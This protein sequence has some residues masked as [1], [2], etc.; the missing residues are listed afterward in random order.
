MVFLRTDLRQ[1]FA[2]EPSSRGLE[3][4]GGGGSTGFQLRPRIGPLI[5][6]LSAHAS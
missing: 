6:W 2:C 1:G 5:F 4:L 3:P